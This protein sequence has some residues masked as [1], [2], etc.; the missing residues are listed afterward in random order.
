MRVE[1][2]VST[3]AA[4]GSEEGGDV[5]AALQDAIDAGHLQHDDGRL[6]VADG[7]LADA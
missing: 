4:S 5:R 7:A 1:V 6:R 2:V 3:L